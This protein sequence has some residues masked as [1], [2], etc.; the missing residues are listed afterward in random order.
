MTIAATY[1]IQLTPN[2]GFAA[3]REL[4]PYL[5]ALGISHAY[6][7]PYGV[8]QPGSTH[9][10]DLV[11]PKRLNPELGGEAELDAW[12]DALAARQMGHIVDFVP[13]H[14][15][16]SP[17]NCWWH[18]VLEN[19]PASVYA[20]HFDIELN[21]PKEALRGKVLL[22]VLGAQYGEVLEKGELRLERDGGSFCVRYWEKAFPI[23]PTTTAPLLLRAVE[24]LGLPPHDPRR[25]DLESI[26]GGMSRLAFE[27]PKERAREKEVLKRR[28]AALIASDEDVAREI[29]AEVARVNG[30]PGD[31]RSFDDL[32]RLLVDQM[33]RLAY[34]RVATEEIN[35]RRFFEINDLAAI[36][37]EC[38]PVFDDMHELVLHL[39]ASGR[40][41]GIRL[42]H[43]DGLY[44][45]A[46][47][48]VKLREAL[49]EAAPKTPIWVIAEKILSA[50]ES[51]PT[52]W[53]ID[54]TTGYDFL[55]AVSG[56]FVDPRAEEPI[57]RLYREVTGD[58]RAFGEHAFEAKR[59]ILRSSLA[60][61]LQMLALRLERLAMRDRRSRDFTQATLRRAI[62]E[63]IAA[64][65]VYRTY[66]RPDGSRDATDA[67]IVTRAIRVARRKNPEVNP[68]VFTFLKD[69]LLF[70]LQGDEDKERAEFAMRFQQLTGPVVAKGVEDTAFYT[71]V[72]FIALNEVGGSPE[73]FGT[74]I[75]TFHALNAEHQARWPMT[76]TTTG[77]HDT[78]RGE[79]VRARLAVLS[80]VPEAFAAWVR[81]WTELA[82]AYTTTIDEEAPEAGRAPSPSDQYLFFQ[83]ALGA[84]PL[85]GGADEGFVRRVAEYMT[86][87]AREAKQHTSWL[88][89]DEAYEGALRGFVEGILADAAFLDSLEGK[90]TAIATYGASNG[91]AQIVLKVASP[92][93]PDTYQGSEEWD[94]RL[95]DPDNRTPVDYE[96]LRADLASLAGATVP[97][98]L[99]AFRDG[100]IKLHVLSR[101]LGLRRSMPRVFVEGD[102]RPIDAGDEI[103]AFEREHDAAALFCAVTR[104]PYGVT[105]G[106]AP[107]ACG[108]VWGDRTIAVPEGRWRDALVDGRELVVGA[109]GVLAAE[110]FR[111][112]PVALLVSG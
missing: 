13:N 25:Q 91:L 54:G 102:Y 101:A 59:T 58:T 5:D 97:D 46:G 73:R 66:V 92:G 28:L 40:L 77:T 32:D 24:E 62:G 78:K 43:V 105:R 34:W 61:E 69:Q 63:T 49:A 3:A 6:A 89:P 103:V 60:S 10:Y 99:H 7:S 29:D 33:Y 86:K 88:A 110:V 39:V 83:T 51:L 21:P 18:D 71:Y 84:Y 57:T 106:M 107:W 55:G 75:P 98:L 96:R 15:A 2:F 26:A 79:D 42:D 22:P 37:M 53:Q 82:T 48:F 30:T 31:P 36:R 74:S 47:Y 80:E 95:V 12:T 93:I 20:D 104:R 70:D 11:D 9:G 81:E 16:A 23:N 85:V 72:R 65:P 19:G 17:Q 50:N 76:M 94:L 8:A 112:L 1:R 38:A 90:A 109:D 27:V 111:D 41:Q 52:S 68:S 87:A 64:F 44:D 14:M 45:P 100:R 67:Q 108:A 4:V 56:L 35:Y